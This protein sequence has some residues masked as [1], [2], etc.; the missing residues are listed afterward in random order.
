MN[1][2]QFDEGQYVVAMTLE[3]A[4]AEYSQVFSAD[5]ASKATGRQLTDEELDTCMIELTDENDEPTGE[6]QSFRAHLLECLGLCMD[7]TAFYLCGK[8]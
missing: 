1:V 8:D 4:W 2:Y 6:M 3:E 7:K 5:P